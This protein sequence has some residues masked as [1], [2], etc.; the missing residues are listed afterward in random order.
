MESLS[1]YRY[2]KSSTT[3]TSASSDCRLRHQLNSDCQLKVFQYL[4]LSDLNALCKV[5]EYFYDIITSQVIPK[6]LIVIEEQYG[7]IVNSSTIE[8]FKMFGK[9]M[10]K[11]TVRGEDFGFFLNTV[12]QYCKPECLTEMHLEFKSNSAD[13]SLIDDSK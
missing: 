7:R 9:F 12:M 1:H 5:D 10:R 13:E 11:I 6:K 3:G 8:S 4:N 2:A